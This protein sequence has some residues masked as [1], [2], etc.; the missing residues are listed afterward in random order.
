MTFDKN[1]D[2]SGTGKENDGDEE[3][4]G[5]HQGKR[6]VVYIMTSKRYIASKIK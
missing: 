2:F 5:T 3:N 1:N 6:K 4:N